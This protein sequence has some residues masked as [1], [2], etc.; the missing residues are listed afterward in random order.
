[1]RILL[2]GEIVSRYTSLPWSQSARTLCSWAAVRM[3][4]SDSA[5]RETFGHGDDAGP[6]IQLPAEP[7]AAGVS[8]GIPP[9]LAADG[10]CR[11]P[12]QR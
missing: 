3:S 8:P 2:V 12:A 6:D 7:G 4:A 11:H 9:V 1:M 5:C 10:A